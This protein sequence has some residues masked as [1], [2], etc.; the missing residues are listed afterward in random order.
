M[1]GLAGTAAGQEVVT[2]TVDASGDWVLI[3]F[4]TGPIQ[5][6]DPVNSLE[7]DLGILSTTIA[8]N[9]GDG[10]PGEV[11]AHCICQ[12]QSLGNDVVQTLTLESESPDFDAV[13]S[14]QIPQDE[15]AWSTTAFDDSPW[16]RYNLMGEHRIW[17]TF[18]VYLVKK[19]DEVYKVQ[20]TNFYGPGDEPRHLTLRYAK[21]AG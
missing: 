21:I 1:F 19:G 9:G 2:H 18:D 6:D 15:S 12:N 13:G 4:D 10:G 3:D 8:V 14:D 16:Y 17:P 20:L 7:W 11:T 5:V